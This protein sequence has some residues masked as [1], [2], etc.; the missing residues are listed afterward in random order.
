MRTTDQRIQPTPFELAKGEALRS[1]GTF[2][3]RPERV[4]AAVFHGCAFFDARDL[5]QVKYEMLRLVSRDGVPVQTAAQAYGF[6]RVAWYQIKARYE[7]CSLSGL[8]P[9]PRG[10]PRPPKKRSVSLR[11]LKPRS[12]ASTM[13]SSGTM[14][15][16]P[17]LSA[18][19][20][21]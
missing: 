7:A 5:V 10:R 8:L 1:Q 16:R 15:S 17:L 19:A 12:C 11:R 20:G 3:P 13:N 2:N 14:R 9:Q 18:T 21:G 4:S 6:S